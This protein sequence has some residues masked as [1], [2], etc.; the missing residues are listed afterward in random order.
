MT[1][2]RWIPLATFLG[3]ILSSQL[4]WAQ[5]RQSLVRRVSVFPVSSPPEH[6]DAA[7][8]AWWAVREELTNN[9]R[10][11]VASTQF[12]KQKDVYQPRIEL[13]PAD[14]ITLGSILDANAVVT[15]YLRDRKF[16]MVVYDGEYGR[17]LWRES[18]A[19]NPALPINDQLQSVAQK[20]T[21]DFVASVPYQ[22]FV[23]V[24]PIIG[25]PTYVE[26]KKTYAKVEIGL[27]SKIAVGDPVQ[28]IR[29]ETA[30]MKPLFAEGGRV[31]VYA[32]GKVVEVDRKTAK[33]EIERSTTE[34]IQEL[35]AVRFPKEIER[36]H[37]QSRLKD[38]LKTVNAHVLATEMNPLEEQV[39]ERKPLVVAVTFIANLAAF[40]LLAF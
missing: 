13:S 1:V 6:Q 31:E 7:E 15:L 25:K 24:D 33:V 23:V 11:L 8:K 4:G 22:G 29:V 18:A 34:P 14:A 38:R 3:L 9:A 37:E 19:L 28:V 21:Q 39:R 2:F 10:F 26:R 16:N 20:L 30:N 17:M 27:N 40:L 5:Y 36:L 32:E 35:S 12:L